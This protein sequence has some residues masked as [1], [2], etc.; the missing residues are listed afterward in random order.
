MANADYDH[1][2]DAQI[3]PDVKMNRGSRYLQN[4]FDSH[5]TEHN[6]RPFDHGVIATRLTATSILE[7]WQLHDQDFTT[8][9]I[10]AVDP[11]K[12]IDPV[13]PTKRGGGVPNPRIQGSQ[14]DVA[15]H[16]QP[17]SFGGN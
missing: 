4:R 8:A 6:N 5:G 12:V 17:G 7:Q 10:N 1:D 13:N 14:V 16:Q 11:H 9:P 15:V 2:G 3:A